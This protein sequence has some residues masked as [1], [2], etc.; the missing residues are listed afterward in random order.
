MDQFIIYENL[1]LFWIGIVGLIV[2]FRMKLKEI[3]RIQALG[4]DKEEKDAP[5][6][7]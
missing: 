7:E 1:V 4:L 5:T 3:E 2:I 6:L